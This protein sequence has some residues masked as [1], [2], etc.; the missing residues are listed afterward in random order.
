MTEDGREILAQVVGGDRNITLQMEDVVTV[1]QRRIH[2]VHVRPIRSDEIEDAL[3]EAGI[4]IPESQEPIEAD[5]AEDDTL[6]MPVQPNWAGGEIE[7]G[8][9]VEFK[10]GEGEIVSGLFA[11][12]Y[13]DGALAVTVEFDGVSTGARVLPENVRLRVAENVQPAVDSPPAPVSTET[14]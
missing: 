11:G 13:E 9:A 6:K 14:K 12:V 8:T 1:A 10:D 3:K 4:D 7:P 5:T 2:H